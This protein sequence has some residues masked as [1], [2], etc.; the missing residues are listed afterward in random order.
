MGL[1]ALPRLAAI[2]LNGVWVGLVL[3][4]VAARLRDVPPIVESVMRIAFLAMPIVWTPELL[5]ERAWLRAFNPFHHLV[6]V[7]RAP[8]LGELPAAEFW[9]AV[10]AVTVVGWAA[11]LALFARCRGRIAYWL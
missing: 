3:G 1:P 11:A 8:L 10:G 9:L 5:S 6:E 2:C 7:V 4:S